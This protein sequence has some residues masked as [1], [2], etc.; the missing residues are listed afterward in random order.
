MIAVIFEVQPADEEKKIE[1]LSIASSL[2]TQLEKMEGFISIERFQSLVNPAK[3]LSL[4]FWKD[5]DCVKK[6][7]T[8]EMHRSAQEKGRLNIFKDYHLR[9]A[10]IVRDYGMFERKE[11]PDDSKEFHDSG[12]VSN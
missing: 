5:E 2:K 11:A 3:I 1:Y 10:V 12:Y 8:L 6:W 7:R 9:V 4:S